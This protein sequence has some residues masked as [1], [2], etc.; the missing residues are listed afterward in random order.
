MHCLLAGKHAV[1]VAADRVDL[2]VVGYE[3]VGMRPFPAWQRVGGKSRVDQRDGRSVVRAL[4]ILIESAELSDQEHSLI[5]DCARR[6]G[7]DVGV[8]GALLKFAADHIQSSVEINTL[9]YRFGFS[10]KTLPDGRHAVARPVTQNLGMNGHFSPSYD[11]NS[12]FV[13]DNFEESSGK[14]PPEPLL[15]QKEHADAVFS[16][17]AEF[18]SGFFG[19]K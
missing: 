3:T 10:E 18:Y 17:I 8:L 2:P 15:R 9:R 7:A 13:G 19:S 4:K 6:Q 14:C 5:D 11:R 16:G 1:R 12:C